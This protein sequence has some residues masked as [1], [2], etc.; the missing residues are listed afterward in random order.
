[1]AQ[2][3]MRSWHVRPTREDIITGLKMLVEKRGRINQK[4]L[5]RYHSAPSVEQVM[6]E[7]G[8]LYDAYKIIGYPPNLDPERSEN[9]NVERKTERLLADVLLE[10]MR[11]QGHQAEYAKHTGTLCI[12][13][14]LR[15]QLVARST[16]LIHGNLPYWV[17]RWPDCFAIDF[18]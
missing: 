6:H 5:K 3:K 12:D 11:R 10:E 2:E 17:A 14:T 8:T 15:I 4:L 13:R 1:K 7:F 9:R 16:W 18:L